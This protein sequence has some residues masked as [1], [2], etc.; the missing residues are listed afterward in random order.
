MQRHDGIGTSIVTTT[1]T[2]MATYLKRRTPLRR[3]SKRRAAELKVYA[4][5]KNYILSQRIYCE[6]PSRTGA[7]TCLNEA[8][9]VHHLRGRHGELLNDTRYWL[10]VCDTC[11]KYIHSHGRE[12]RQKGLLK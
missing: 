6:C 7:P 8:T 12:S 10:V 1:E 3:V 4:S 9:Q 2:R 5:L 11:H